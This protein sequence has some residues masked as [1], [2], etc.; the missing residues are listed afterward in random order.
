MQHNLCSLRRH[1]VK[2]TI[3]FK[4]CKS[5]IVLMMLSILPMLISVWKRPELKKTEAYCIC[6]LASFIFG[7]HVHEK[8]ILLSLLPLA[9][10][11]VRNP[12]GGLGKTFLIL[13]SAGYSGLLPLIFTDFEQPMIILLFAC[14]EL[15]TLSL[16]ETQFK[17]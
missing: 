15:F 11:A 2:Y 14:S 10:V 1:N 6:A 5:C 12:D 16:F 8:A 3:F 4:A 13:S 17:R 7:Y 9:V